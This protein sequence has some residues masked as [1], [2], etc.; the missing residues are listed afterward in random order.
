MNLSNAAKGL[1]E[2]RTERMIVTGFRNTM[3]GYD[4][5]DP[6]CW[7]D[8]WNNL[9]AEGGI[10]CARSVS[11]NLQYFIRSLRSACVRKLQYFPTS[12]RRLCADECLIISL[13]SAC[14]HRTH[15]TLQFCLEQLISEDA[16][17]TGA[18]LQNSA[19][20]LAQE[21]SRFELQLLPVPLQVIETIVQRTCAAC[22]ERTICNVIN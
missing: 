9:V 3:A 8:S 13:L 10:D 17:V 15:D 2:F 7:D 21:L 19:G 16:D 18:E 1:F 12:C 6:S 5:G 14:Q 11:G 20:Y 4:L 22:Q